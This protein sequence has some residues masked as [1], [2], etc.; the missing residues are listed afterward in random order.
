MVKNIITSNNILKIK[1]TIIIAKRF[2][3]ASN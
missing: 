1:T 3:V 2:K